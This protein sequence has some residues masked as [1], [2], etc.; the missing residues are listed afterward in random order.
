MSICRTTTLAACVLICEMSTSSSLCRRTPLS[1]QRCVAVVRA[2]CMTY[3][4]PSLCRRMRPS[5][6]HRL[7]RGVPD[8]GVYRAEFRA[9]N[10][11]LAEE[12]CAAAPDR[13]IGMGTPFQIPLTEISFSKS[14][15]SS[16]V[17]K[18]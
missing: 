3:M 2:S 13:L 12:Y 6:R 18:P 15:F 4:T 5:R 16:C 10:Q 11:F 17:R 8:Q 7:W 9:W 1:P 14:D